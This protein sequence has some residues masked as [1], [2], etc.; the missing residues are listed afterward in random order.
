MRINKFLASSGIASRRKAEEY[1][2]AGK[3]KVNGV[4]VYNLGTD[5]C[6]TDK[7]ICDGKAVEPAEKFEYYMLNK[8]AGYICSVSDDKNRKIVTELIKSNSR[9]YPVGRLDY[10][11]EGLLLL[12][13][14]G[15]L[16]FKLTHPKNN[17]SKTYLVDI[18]SLISNDELQKLQDGIVI[19]NYKLHKCKIKVLKCYNNQTEL[20]MTVFEGRNREI[21]KMFESFGQNVLFLRRT[22][23]E[24]LELG[25]LKIGQYRSLSQKEIEYLNSV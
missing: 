7:V 20:E 19:D 11:S 9:I 24:K 3:V 22:K 15:D 21:R 18:D 1:I 8:P 12:T 23:I 10:E 17:I 2:L 16:T 14:D 4:V 25:N 5:I 13:N 6:E